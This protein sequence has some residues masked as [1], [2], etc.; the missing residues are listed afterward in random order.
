MYGFAGQPAGEDSA[1]NFS[2]LPQALLRDGK[3]QSP[4]AITASAGRDASM[5]LLS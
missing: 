4:L 2:I 3:L 1:V 5:Q